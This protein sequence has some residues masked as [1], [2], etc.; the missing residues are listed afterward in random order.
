MKINR[1]RLYLNETD[2]ATYT[3]SPNYHGDIVSHDYI[4]IHY[5]AGTSAESSIAWLTDKRAQAS[6][7]LVIGRDGNITQLVPFNKRAWH[8]GASAWEN[9]IGLNRYSIGIEL[10]NA[11]K[12]TQQGGKWKNWSEHTFKD[13]DV[14]VAVHKNENAPTGWHTYTQ[15]QIESALA[16]CKTLV[17]KYPTIK[18]IVGHD[19]IAPKRKSDP[20]PAF[21]M[22]SFRSH[23]LGR[24]E[25]EDDIVMHTTT[26]LN[27]RVGPGA[28]HQKLLPDGLPENTRVIVSHSEG[29][30][31]FVDVIDEVVGEQDLE[32]WV[33][34]RY[35]ES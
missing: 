14:I 8:A 26:S 19:D 15:A 1:H 18:D 10:D 30:W 29:N 12:L 5:T 33:H 31:K 27:I 32:G 6:A 20:G 35:L 7:H 16:V 34:G 2:A 23:V 4:V 24:K 9:R 3:A 28:E 25:D 11:G 22:N 17:D 13:S 21:A